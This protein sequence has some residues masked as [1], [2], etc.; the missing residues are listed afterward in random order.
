V[1]A[2]PTPVAA[3]AAEERL[4]ALERLLQAKPVP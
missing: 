4:A 2:A 3:A 1:D